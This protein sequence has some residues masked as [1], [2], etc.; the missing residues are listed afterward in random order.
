ML[1]MGELSHWLRETT[2]L[3]WP[4]LFSLL[5][6]PSSTCPGQ[7]NYQCLL[8]CHA[9]YKHQT[10]SRGFKSHT[11]R[12]FR[13]DSCRQQGHWS[14]AWQGNHILRKHPPSIKPWLHIYAELKTK[15]NQ[16]LQDFRP[17][18][19]SFFFTQNAQ[20]RKKKA[21]ISENKSLQWWIR[22]QSS[23]Y[24]WPSRAQSASF[25]IMCPWNK[26]TCNL[27]ACQTPSTFLY[28]H[29]L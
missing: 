8:L 18:S 24:D 14:W 11:H 7:F 21:S 27:F 12:R 2:D 23:D 9:V 13:I 25:N 1:K 15:K 19:S 3:H 20:K 6:S 5:P 26:A 10:P 4:A 22:F 29:T 17:S 16:S 28:I